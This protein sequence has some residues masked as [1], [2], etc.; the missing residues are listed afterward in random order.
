MECTLGCVLSDLAMFFS[1][2]CNFQKVR[3]WVRVREGFGDWFIL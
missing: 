1:G 3:F 2:F